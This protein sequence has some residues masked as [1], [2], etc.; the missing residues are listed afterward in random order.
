[1]PLPDVPIATRPSMVTDA[2]VFRLFEQAERELAAARARHAAAEE[3]WGT[4]PGRRA[5][6]ERNGARYAL[7]QALQQVALVRGIWDTTGR[8]REV[9]SARLERA[10]WRD[11]AYLVVEILG[12]G[13]GEGP[14]ARDVAFG[15]L[16]AGLL[17]ELLE[18]RHRHL[19]TQGYIFAGRNPGQHLG[20]HAAGRIVRQLATRAGVQ[21]VD[22]PDQRTH[23][24]HVRAKDI[25]R[26]GEARAIYVGGA[27]PKAAAQV[28]GHSE[29]MQERHYLGATEDDAVRIAQARDVP[30][31]IPDAFTRRVGAGAPP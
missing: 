11:D 25:R 6:T 31:F 12:K 1:M 22:R 13:H 10:I 8:V 28:A 21:R 26:R 30:P 20:V 17:R 19:P 7:D 29:E 18:R 2:Q 15:P 27:A 14:V 23:R 9:V 24:Y 3:A 5:R 16:T 4:C